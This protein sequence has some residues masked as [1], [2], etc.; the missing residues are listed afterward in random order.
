MAI[1]KSVVVGIQKSKPMAGAAKAPECVPVEVRPGKDAVTREAN[2]KMKEK[3]GLP[4]REKCR[5]VKA[6]CLNPRSSVLI[7]QKRKRCRNTKN[8]DSNP[9]I[10]SPDGQ[11]CWSNI[12]RVV[13]A[14]FCRQDWW[15]FGGLGPLLLDAFEHDAINRR[16]RDVVARKVG[17][18]GEGGFKAAERGNCQ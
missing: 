4:V 14:H 2:R 6:E 18:M 5:R 10:G 1:A 11:E 3:R 9:G 12:G 8:L 15:C 16:W 17:T 7:R 13:M